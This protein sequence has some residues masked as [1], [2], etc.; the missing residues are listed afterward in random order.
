MRQL[1]TGTVTL[2]FTDIE[3]S[4]RLLQELGDEYEDVLAEHRRLVREAVAA[5]SGVEVDTQGDA[6]L[7]AFAR[8]SDAAAAAADAQHALAHTQVRVRMGVHTGEPTR[9]DEGYV[10][11]DLHLGARVM[12]AGHGGQ[13]VLTASTRMRLGDGLPVH[14]LGEHRLKDLREPLHLYQLGEQEFP[15]LRTLNNTNLPVPP[16]P[17]VGRERELANVLALVRDGAR[18]LT[19][20]GPGGT[21]KTRLALEAAAELVGEFAS[22][23][24]LAE[25]APLADPDLVA[26]AIA[27]TLGVRERTDEPLTATLAAHVEDKRLLLLLDNFEHVTEAA[28]LLGDLLARAPKLQALATSRERLQLAGEREYEV[29]TLTEEDAVALFR[30]RSPRPLPANGAVAELCCRLD[31]LPLALELAA[32]RTKLLSPE[33]LLERLGLKLLAGGARD[34]PERQRTLRATIEW[35]Y[36]LLSAEEQ[37]LFRRL[38]V[39]AGGFSLEAAEH[40]CKADLDA[41]ASLVDKSLVRAEEERFTM[42][43]TIREF[44]AERLDASGQAQAWRERHASYF[45][46]LAEEAGPN[47]VGREQSSWLGRLEAE[48]PNLR[49]AFETLVI[50]ADA[51]GLASF[52]GSLWRFWYA[53][54]HFREGRARLEEAMRTAEGVSPL[55]Q[56]RLLDGLAEILVATGEPDQAKPLSDQSIAIWRASGDR[57]ALARALVTRQTT[58]YGQGHE[59]WIAACDEGIT[60][61]READETWAL[62]VSL[63][64]LGFGRLEEGKYHEAR[65]LSSEAAQ[66]LAEVGDV[67]GAANSIANAAS[68]ALAEGLVDE[69]V[70]HYRESTRFAT[71]VGA[72]TLIAF[73][74]DG[75]AAAALARGQAGAAVTL[76]GASASLLDRIG[77]VGSARF[78][79]Q[80]R[81]TTIAAATATL[82]ERQFRKALDAGAAMS[83]DE[84]LDYAF[85]LV[86]EA[87]P[88]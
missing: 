78:E 6:F 3:G 85:E 39:F 42:L 2:L 59:P 26:P 56:A 25:L 37:E 46:S 50:A 35:S 75:L 68:A 73:V 19:L 10:G 23:V 43:E 53:R 48:Q 11:L 20:T 47:L 38:A 41:L 83:S 62:A 30:E 58:A 36:D 21:G 33:Q 27:Q 8:A 61:A 13:V 74:L 28:P 54:G 32:A 55:L 87:R 40:V 77:F 57:A 70:E 16:S 66:L 22:G 63:S 9:T 82:G 34:L 17:L 45:L 49:A 52:A 1:P 72:E 12:A 76:L 79:E 14:D 65:Q 67:F 86:S 60:V 84:A 71:E 44:A 88:S 24:F 29:P 81:Q 5:H 51:E 69:A 7:C 31:H 15:P 4:T 18:L 80:R 64:N